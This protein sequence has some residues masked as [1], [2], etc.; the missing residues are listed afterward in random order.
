MQRST[1]NHIPKPFVFH[2]LCLTEDADE[3]IG[4][5]VTVL[6]GGVTLVDSAASRLHQAKDDGV[7]QHL[8]AQVGRRAWGQGE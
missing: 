8:S 6:V 4:Q 2:I 3:G 5:Q 1:H 7:T